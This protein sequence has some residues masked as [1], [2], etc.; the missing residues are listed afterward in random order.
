MG[1]QCSFHIPFHL[2]DAAGVLFF[3]HVFSIAHQAFEQFVIQQLA[4]SWKE[5]FQNPDWVVP[6][7]HAEAEYLHP[8]N[9]GEICCFEISIPAIHTTSFTLSTTLSQQQQTSCIVKT[10]HVFCNRLSKQKIPIPPSLL[11]RLKTT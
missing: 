6:I 4:C 9:G 3:G 8:L 10:V 7:K 11:H 1:F 5:W 2:T